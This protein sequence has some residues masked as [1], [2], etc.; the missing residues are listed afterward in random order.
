MPVTSL[1]EQLIRDE[2][3]IPYVYTDSL[4]FYTVGV[5]HLCDKRR[6]GGLPDSIIAALLDYDIAT[7]SADMLKAFPWM[8]TLDPVRFATMANM[9]FQLG[10]TGLSQFAK[11]LAY[12][13]SGEYTAASLSFADSKVAREQ[14]PERWKRHCKQIAT[15]EWV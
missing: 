6:G 12:M 1:R 3:C 2:G 9:C 14:T 13:K 8:D 10:V 7:H 4:G 5:G 15:G 11:S